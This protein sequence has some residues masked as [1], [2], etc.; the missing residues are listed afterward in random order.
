MNTLG[1]ILTIVAIALYITYITISIAYTSPYTKAKQEAKRTGIEYVEP[2]LTEEQKEHA[3]CCPHRF[4]F[5]IGESWIKAELF[6][7]SASKFKCDCNG[8]CDDKQKKYVTGYVDSV[9]SG[10]NITT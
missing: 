7:R 10:L 1:K 3:D 6:I 4:A 5:E 9:I 8:Y 2:E